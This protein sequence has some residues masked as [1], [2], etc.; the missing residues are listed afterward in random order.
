MV[1]SCKYS[2]TL[3]H[4]IKPLQL[5]ECYYGKRIDKQ[6]SQTENPETYVHVVI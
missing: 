4:A 2:Q 5:I 6:I 1:D 3:M